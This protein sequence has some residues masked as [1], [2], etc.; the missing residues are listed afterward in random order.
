MQNTNQPEIV[1]YESSLKPFFKSLNCEWLNKYFSVTE[2][3]EKILSDPENIIGNGGCVIFARLK[4]KIVGTCALIKKSDHEYEIAKMGVTEEAQGMK[5]GLKLLD[6]IIEE[7]KIRKAKIISLETAKSLK[8]AISL[9][10]KVGFVQTSEEET[11][12]L[13]KRRTFRMELRLKA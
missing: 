13:F 5:V 1:F 4:D 11:H 10:Q 7:A 8:A 9:Y 2:E 6:S 3:D 12:P